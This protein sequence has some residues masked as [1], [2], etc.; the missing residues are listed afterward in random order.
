MANDGYIL[1]SFD[2]EEFDMPLE[3]GQKISEEEQLRASFD[4]LQVLR[5]TLQQLS[6]Q[7]TFFT[8]GN[9]AQHYPDIIRDLS[10]HHE[11]ASHT[12]FHSAFAKADLKKS[13]EILEEITGR[14]IFGIRMP[15][16]A[17]ADLPAIRA[18]GY[19][20]DSSLNPTYLPGRY[21]N[22][23]VSRTP[24][25]EEGVMRFPVSVSPCLRIPLFWLSFKN[26][27]YFLYLHLVSK[28]IKK[29]G[30]V[31]LYFH[32]WEFIN[33]KKYHIP[34]YTKRW[35]GKKL[36]NRLRKL[37]HDLRPYGSFVAINQYIAHRCKNVSTDNL[38][39]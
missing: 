31:C 36:E 33:L 24:F 12:L 37:V 39:S 19:S 35:S 8:T 5:E 2:V 22:L 6:I 4:G 38:N 18:A 7:V 13:K 1:L 17:R 16:M 34:Q 25:V 23:K 11:I 21:N 9:F 26:L 27:P 30:Y 3:Y 15:R 29:D 32:P 20:Y 28:T 14:E 10:V